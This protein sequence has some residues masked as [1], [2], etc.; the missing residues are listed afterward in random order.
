MMMM[1][2]MMNARRTLITHR[3]LITLEI[4]IMLQ[5]LILPQQTNLIPSHRRVSPGLESM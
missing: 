3:V 1:L 5:T 2:L 4:L